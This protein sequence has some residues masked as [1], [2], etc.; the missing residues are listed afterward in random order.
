MSEIIQKF[1]SAFVVFEVKLLLLENSFKK[2]L[3]HCKLKLMI[4]ILTCRQKVL[5]IKSNLVWLCIFTTVAL[6]FVRM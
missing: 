6:F 2:T 4:E 5:Y 3:N 1:M